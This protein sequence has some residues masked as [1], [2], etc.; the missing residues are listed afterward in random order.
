MRIKDFSLQYNV[1]VAEIIETLKEHKIGNYQDPSNLSNDQIEFLKK[2]LPLVDTGKIF[3]YKL[4][5]DQKIVVH[6]MTVG[7]LAISCNVQ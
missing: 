3:K 2:H 1:P 4:P 5:S 7:D 6:D